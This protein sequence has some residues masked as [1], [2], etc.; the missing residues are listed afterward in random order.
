MRIDK[1][2]NKIKEISLWIYI[3]ALLT[4]IIYAVFME[5]E[6]ITPGRILYEKTHTR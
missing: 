1:S 3:A 2:I 4:G 6:T 5:Q